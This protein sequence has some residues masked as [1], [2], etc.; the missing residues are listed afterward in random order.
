[1]VNQRLETGR[2]WARVERTTERAMRS[3]ALQPIPTGCDYVEHQGVRFIVRVVDYLKRER[4]QAD[5]PAAAPSGLQANPFLPHDE[6]LFV[7]HVSTTH[8]CVLNK[9][10]VV[11]HHLLIV[12]RE[13][14]HQESA[15]T[16]NDFE[17]LWLCMAEYDALGFYNAGVVAGASQPHK[18][19]QMVPLPLAPDGPATPVDPLVQAALAGGGPAAA[20][21][22][23]FRHLLA[24]LEPA[25]PQ[26]MARRSLDLY[27]SM[28]DAAG[29]W[30]KKRD[31]A[32]ARPAPYNLLATRRWM[33]LVPR[34][35]EHYETVSVNALGFAGALLARDE[36]ERD[37]LV[38]RGPMTALCEVA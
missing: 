17:A 11:D 5:R 33:M 3:G 30:P 4:R 26:R 13:F 32:D 27:R 14:E 38:E 24:R 1:V 37:L 28:L 15:L 9:F 21:G 6:E 8:L 34:S 19:L 35:R 16:L 29:V 20:P 25:T 2:L 18:H 12:T 23:P 10:N 31:A 36:A 22:L 7:D